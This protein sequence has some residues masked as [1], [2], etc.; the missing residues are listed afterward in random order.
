MRVEYYTASRIHGSNLYVTI[1]PDPDNTM[2]SDKSKLQNLMYRRYH[3]SHKFKNMESC[4]MLCIN[5]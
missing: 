1:E 3:F 2:L 5:T 4:Y